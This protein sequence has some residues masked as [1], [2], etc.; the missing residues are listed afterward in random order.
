MDINLKYQT[1]IIFSCFDY[2]CKKYFIWSN[3]KMFKK[4]DSDDFKFMTII[5]TNFTRQQGCHK[6][7]LFYD[8]I[9]KQM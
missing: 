2:F 3:C 6:I 5:F 4:F 1:V 7:N 8:F 9:W